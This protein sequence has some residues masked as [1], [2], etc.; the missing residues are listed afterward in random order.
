MKLE[1][2][3][4]VALDG[5]SEER[6]FLLAA[7]LKDLAWGFKIND[8]L[9]EGTSI[10]RKL[11]KFGKVFADAKLHDI[12]NTVGN[13]VEKISGAG[14]DIITVH[15]SGGIDMMRAAKKHAGRSKIIAVTVLTSSSGGRREIARSVSRL[16]SDAVAARLDGVVC[17]AHDLSLLRGMKKG[18]TFLAVVPGIRP[19]WYAKKDDQHRSATPKTAMEAGAGL[20]VVGRPITMS[21]DPVRATKDILAEIGIC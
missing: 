21:K 12:P 2:P 9:F 18:N 7:S 4:I 10:I 19:D 20:L 1:S 6:A 5:M 16:M 8:L 15:A 3:I 17:S 11:K 14:A 13:S